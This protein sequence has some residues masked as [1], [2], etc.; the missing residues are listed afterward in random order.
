M[1]GCL[2]ALWR[3]RDEAGVLRLLGSPLMAW[4][5]LL[6]LVVLSPS[7]AAFLFHRNPSLPYWAFAYSVETVCIASVLLHAMCFPAGALGRLLNTRPLVHI[8]LISYSL[9]LWQQP[10]LLKAIEGA[11][12]GRVALNLG[13]VFLIA[14]ASYR[15]VE[16]PAINLGRR[17][18]SRWL[19]ARSGAPVPSA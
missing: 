17:L 4:G 8:G 7:L 3:E 9:Y 6:F 11:G 13:A 12:W 5:S 1:A 10:F 19:G 18:R 16:T 14:E 2:L 15:F